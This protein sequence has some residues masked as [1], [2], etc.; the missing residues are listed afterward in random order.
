MEEQIVSRAWV[1]VAQQLILIFE[2]VI[3]EGFG[4]QVGFSPRKE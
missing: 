1:Y 2:K 4:P 3:G